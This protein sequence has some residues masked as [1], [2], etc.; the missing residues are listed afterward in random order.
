MADRQFNPLRVVAGKDHDAPNDANALTDTGAGSSFDDLF[1]EEKFLGILF[2]AQ[3]SKPQGLAK[4]TS[5]FG[6]PLRSPQQ[7][8][9]V[10]MAAPT[11][12]EIDAKLEASE[13]RV[14]AR[15]SGIEATLKILLDRVEVSVQA[16]RDAKTAADDAKTAAG[17]TKWNILFTALGVLAVIF[18]VW[19]VW[20]QGIEMVSG[21]LSAKS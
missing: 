17:N 11:R 4:D 16:S 13:A 18:A 1:P 5:L 8:E 10:K 9:R 19:A 6:R 21:L 7:R 3:G 15:L 20:A 12:E 14:D 2:A